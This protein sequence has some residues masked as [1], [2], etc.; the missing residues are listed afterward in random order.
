MFLRVYDF[1]DGGFTCLVAEGGEA[2]AVGGEF[3]GLAERLL[4]VA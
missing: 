3:G 4:F 1:E 2:Q